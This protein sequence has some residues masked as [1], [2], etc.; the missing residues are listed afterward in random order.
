LD[1]I[2]LMPHAYVA[3][4]TRGYPIDVNALPLLLQ[5]PVAYVGAIGSQRRWLT[6]A[7][8]LRRWA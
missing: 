1:K 8:A 6:A 5:A 3:L 7:N 4:V 2:E